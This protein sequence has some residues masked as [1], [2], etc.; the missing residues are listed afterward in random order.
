MSERQYPCFFL[1]KTADASALFFELSPSE[2]FCV[3]VFWSNLHHKEISDY[4]FN[5]A[6]GV[7]KVPIYS[8]IP[9]VDVPSFLTVEYEQ[10]KPADIAAMRQRGEL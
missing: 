9:L 2:F 3:K 4:V 6:R 5:T 10:V 1:R 8:D 7:P